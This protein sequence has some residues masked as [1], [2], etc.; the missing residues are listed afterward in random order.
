M[1]QELIETYL[2]R[3]GENEVGEFYTSANILT[4]ITAY[5]GGRVAVRARDISICMNRLAMCSAMWATS[6]DGMW[7]PY[8]ATIS[9][10]IIA[11][12]P[13]AVGLM[14]RNNYFS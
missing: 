5:C 7:C 6:E 11:S 2:R 10:I 14:K 4:A 9:T 3:P 12:M 13:T 8:R 1:V